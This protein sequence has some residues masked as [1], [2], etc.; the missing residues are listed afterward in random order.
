MTLNALSFLL[1]LLPVA[2]ATGW[3]IGRRNAL[4]G[5]SRPVSVNSDYLKGLQYLV[6]EDADK[7]IEV[8]VH[9]LEVD[10]ETVETHLALG[11]LFRRQGEVDRAL[12]IHQNLV[13]RPNLDPMHRN[14][15][16]YE[17][18][19]DY[20]KAGVL[21]RAENLFKDLADQGIFRERSLKG[22]ISIYEQERDWSAAVEIS[23]QLETTQG[24]SLRPV[25][26]QYHCELAEQALRQKEHEEALSLIRLAL[27]EHSDC[28]RASLMEGRIEEQNENFRKALKAYQR[29]MD[30]DV[31]FV[32][33]ILAPLERCFEALGDHD[34]WKTQLEKLISRFDGAAPRLAMAGLLERE[35]KQQLAVDYLADYLQT[36]TSWLVFHHLLELSQ[37]DL[38]EHFGESLE[39]LQNALEKMIKTSARYHCSNC[40]FEGP[41]LHWQ[42]LR[43]KQWNALSPVKDVIP[44]S[45]SGAAYVPTSA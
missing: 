2:A 9:L 13:A 11:N 1:L 4:L 18:A 22:L 28:V 14:Q 5:K 20:L 10:N 7:A 40:G 21:D 3:V 15:A 32:G 24:H 16:R 31:E 36:H 35:N 42:C 41:S 19:R 26:A 38:H 17:L 44:D 45:L 12:K 37:T 29:V 6:N 27:K 8:F 39:T 33:E 34:G 23:R 43:C 30:Q 25:I